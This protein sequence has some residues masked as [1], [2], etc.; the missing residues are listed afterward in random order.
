MTLSAREHERD[1]PVARHVPGAAAWSYPVDAAVTAVRRGAGAAAD[2]LALAAPTALRFSLALVFVWFGVLKV[3]GSSP[4]IGLLT[5]TVPWVEPHLLLRGLGAFEV[6]LGLGLLVGRAQ[7]GLLLLLA[8]HLTGTFLTF[9][10]ARGLVLQHGNPLLL[11]VDGEFVL[12]NL[13]LITAA[14]LLVG[15]GAGASAVRHR[16]GA[17]LEVAS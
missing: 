14:L 16:V 5:A 4:V 13:V 7:R 17:E 10:T 1:R 8:T 6:L 12:K 11:T 2:R 9:V 15:R 3:A